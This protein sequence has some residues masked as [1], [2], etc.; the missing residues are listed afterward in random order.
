M[1]VWP[2]KPI[3]IYNIDKLLATLPL[4]NWICQPKWDGKRVEPWC[5][6]DGKIVLYG[7]Q[8]QVFP[9]KWAWLESLPLERPWLL[10]GELLRDGR[11]IVWDYAIM[12]GSN[13]YRLPYS[14]RLNLLKCRLQ[15]K[16]IGNQ[17]FSLIETYPAAE[18]ER[19]LN[20][21]KGNQLEGIVFKSLGSTNL[22]GVHSTSE[23]GT[24]FK[25]RF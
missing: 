8:G 20:R 10:D 7:R 9:E 15:P 3:R 14:E 4:E 13:E 21:V 6:E 23:V 11:M 12:G 25:Y 2:N 17:S 16:S 18:Y 24:Q 1:F 19:I 5:D 22:W